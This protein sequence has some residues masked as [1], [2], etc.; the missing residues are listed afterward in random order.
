MKRMNLTMTLIMALIPLGSDRQAQERLLGPPLAKGNVV[1]GL[2]VILAGSS[3][4][5]DALFQTI[6][7]VLVALGWGRLSS[8]K[9]S[10]SKG[11]VA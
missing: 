10:I 6:I 4:L 11:A 5:A 7:M 1:V 9:A 3:A 2:M 8:D